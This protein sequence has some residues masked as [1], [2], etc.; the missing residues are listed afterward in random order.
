[1]AL[2]DKD[3]TKQIA[4]SLCPKCDRSTVSIPEVGVV[5]A[6]LRETFAK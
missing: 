5:T 2:E 4:K 1:M 3:E 6:E